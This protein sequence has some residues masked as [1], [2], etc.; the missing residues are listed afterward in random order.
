MGKCTVLGTSQGDWAEASA[1]SV[2]DE[3]SIGGPAPV[4]SVKSVKSEQ[5]RALEGEPAGGKGL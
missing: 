3:H 2:S 5:S 1:L 4:K